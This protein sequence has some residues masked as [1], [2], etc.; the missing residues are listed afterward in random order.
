MLKKG[1][2][3]DVCPQWVRTVQVGRL[4]VSPLDRAGDVRLPFL[5]G[6]AG[7]LHSS[8]PQNTRQVLV[9]GRKRARS[10]PHV[11]KSK[12]I[13]YCVPCKLRRGGRCVKLEISYLILHSY[14]ERL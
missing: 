6:D 2:S 11:T 9:V 4:Q 13:I 10:G 12:E 5:P 8:P 7:P 1:T 14:G 3:G